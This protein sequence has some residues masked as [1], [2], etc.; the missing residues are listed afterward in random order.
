VIGVLRTDTIRIFVQSRSMTASAGF[1]LSGR[2]LDHR[3]GFVDSP[4]QVI[5]FDPQLR[6]QDANAPDSLALASSSIPGKAASTWQRALRSVIPRSSSKPRIWLTTAVRRVTIV[7]VPSAGTSD[8]LGNP[9][10]SRQFRALAE[11]CDRCPPPKSHLSPSLPAR[12]IKAS[13]VL[14]PV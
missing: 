13:K 12:I 2:L 11:S 5:E 8:A 4:L 9:C 10:G 3:I 1:V 6:Q 14:A 7:R